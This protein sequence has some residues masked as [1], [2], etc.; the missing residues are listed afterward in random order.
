MA[1][2][3]NQKIG[4][5]ASGT[6]RSGVLQCRAGLAGGTD[7][8]HQASAGRHLRGEDRLV[9]GG[10][11]AA[12][13]DRAGLTGR[14]IRTIVP[15][16]SGGAD[17]IIARIAGRPLAESLKQPVVVDNGPGAGANIAW[18]WRQRRRLTTACR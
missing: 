12:H 5:A 14:P 17:D 15:N 8:R 3:Y 2:Y 10:R 9:R 11:P 16:P 6:R 13:D 4:A 7:D 1:T 18:R